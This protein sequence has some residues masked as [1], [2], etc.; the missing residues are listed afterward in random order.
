L[1]RQ[2]DQIEP[3]GRANQSF[4]KWKQ[5]K[6]SN[7]EY[8]EKMKSAI[9][10]PK[11]T[12]PMPIERYDMYGN[13]INFQEGAHR[14]V[15]A[16][17]LGQPVPV[18]MVKETLDIDKRE[19]I[20]DPHTVNKMWSKYVKPIPKITQY[21]R[22]VAKF[23]PQQHTATTAFHAGN[24]PPSE[25]LKQ[26][27]KVYAF[28]NQEAA[29]QW[30]QDKGKDKVYQFQT[31]NYDLDKKQYSRNTKQP[32]RDNEIIAKDVHNEQELDLKKQGYYQQQ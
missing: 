30:K 27:G 28:P 10:D 31:N 32:Y 5:E 13:R 4:E 22:E 8:I 20:N 17:E 11:Q 2:Y 19:N 25:E 24:I 23:I 6:A 26:K 29:E 7:R 14:G 9:K 15:S 16:E 21:D 12:V 1:R 18:I 3:E